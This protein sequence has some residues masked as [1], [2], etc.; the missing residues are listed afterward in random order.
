MIRIFHSHSRFLM[1]W[2]LKRY[3]KRTVRIGSIMAEFRK[4][5]APYQKK[6]QCLNIWS[7]IL[8][9]SIQNL[10]FLPL[11]PIPQLQPL[12]LH[13]LKFVRCIA[14]STS[15]IEILMPFELLVFK[16]HSS[17]LVS[18]GKCQL[19]S[20]GYLS[21]RTVVYTSSINRHTKINLLVIPYGII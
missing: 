11:L 5:Y 19:S 2:H 1:L 8:Q 9:I 20:M 12:L 18:L 21:Q 4:V 16:Q 6:L 3:E 14:Y 15:M 13:F 7:W 10:P 17:I